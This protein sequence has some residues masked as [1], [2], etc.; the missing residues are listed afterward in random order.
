MFIASLCV[1][2]AKNIFYILSKK[3][4]TAKPK[5][6]F[7]SQVDIGRVCD[8]SVSVIDFFLPVT[9]STSKGGLCRLVFL[10]IDENIQR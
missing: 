6:I 10:D 2:T 1:D 8:F 7:G 4:E 9:C 3:S 5:Y